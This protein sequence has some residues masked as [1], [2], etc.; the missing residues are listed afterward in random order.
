MSSVC[1]GLKE[2]EERGKK[3][4]KGIKKKIETCLSYKWHKRDISAQ[5]VA[6]ELAALDRISR[7]KRIQEIR[8]VT[9]PH[10]DL[11]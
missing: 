5:E 10:I 8:S 4:R 7:T 6:A 9:S 2:G 11:K 3:K 1:P